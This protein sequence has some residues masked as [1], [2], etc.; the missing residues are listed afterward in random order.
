MHSPGDDHGLVILR[1]NTEPLPDQLDDLYVLRRVQSI[2]YAIVHAL[3][4]T[5]DSFESLSP[6]NYR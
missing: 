4:R 5:F 1:L 3:R 2:V 6:H